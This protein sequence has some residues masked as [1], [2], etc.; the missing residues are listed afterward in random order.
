MLNKYPVKKTLCIAYNAGAYGTYLEWLLNT[1]CNNQPIQDPFSKSGVT[2]GNSHNSTLG[3]QLRTIEGWRSYKQSSQDLATLRLHPKT[4]SNHNIA[5]NLQE[6]LQDC[7]RSILIYPS[8]GHEL[9]CINNWFTKVYDTED[10]L[11]GALRNLDIDQ[12]RK[13]WP[14][15]LHD[16]AAIP[17][18]IL[19]EYLSFYLVPAWLDQVEWFFPDRWQHERCF[20]IYTNELLHQI[21]PT[22]ERIRDF[23]GKEFSKDIKDIM[24]YHDQMLNLQQHLYQDTL[25]QQIVESVLDPNDFFGWAPLT[26][27]S[28]SWVQWKLRTMGIEIR[29]NRLDVFP[30]NNQSLYELSYQI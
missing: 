3:R 28:E 5:D 25:C 7:E 27:A 9:L 29:C 2:I 18:W 21:E 14:I 17:R 22:L 30:T 15:D 1:L 13:N 23:W 24:R 4:Q 11:Q 6:I 20:V 19:R 8:P 10:V 16:S 26:L 12:I